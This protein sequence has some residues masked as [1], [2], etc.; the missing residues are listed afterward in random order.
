M[1]NLLPAVTKTL[2]AILTKH[3]DWEVRFKAGP[4]Q[5]V[6]IGICT[7][8]ANAAVSVSIRQIELGK[9]DVLPLEI[10]RLAQHMEVV[11]LR[12]QHPGLVQ[13]TDNS[14]PYRNRNASS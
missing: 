14:G 9:F 7:P 4:F 1:N 10:G 11:E 8:T 13:Q 12:N 3:P 2:L 6:N 5:T